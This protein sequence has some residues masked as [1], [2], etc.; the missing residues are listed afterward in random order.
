VFTE[1]AVPLHLPNGL[2]HFWKCKAVAQ[3]VSSVIN[4]TTLF[5]INIDHVDI[6]P[7]VTPEAALHVRGSARY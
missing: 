6:G 1:D 5:I 7:N 3:I 2:I 4:N